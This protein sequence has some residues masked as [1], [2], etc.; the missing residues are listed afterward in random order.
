MEKEAGSAVLVVGEEDPA[1][2]NTDEVARTLGSF[3][4]Q[5]HRTRVAT[6]RTTI[7]VL[8]ACLLLALLFGRTTF[9]RWSQV[10]R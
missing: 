7:F 8:T 4:L 9:R 5:R 10:D 1:K 6:G 2:R 3:D